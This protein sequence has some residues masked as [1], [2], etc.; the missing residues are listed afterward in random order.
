MGRE[1]YLPSFSPEKERD[2]IKKRAFQDVRPV[3]GLPAQWRLS[4][5]LN[6]LGNA[7]S[8]LGGMR[9]IYITNVVVVPVVV[10]IVH[11]VSSFSSISYPCAADDLFVRGKW[12]VELRIGGV[13]LAGLDNDR[14]WSNEGKE[15]RRVDVFRNV[16]MQPSPARMVAVM[17]YYIQ[18]G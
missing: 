6:H 9:G 7:Q 3:I 4:S 15:V 16:G 5:W 18:I 17:C 14:P 2:Q 12:S 8:Q 1:L 13:G 11:K 10:K